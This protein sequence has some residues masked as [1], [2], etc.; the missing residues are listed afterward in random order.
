MSSRSLL[1]GRGTLDAG[2]RRLNPSQAGFGRASPGSYST[3]RGALAADR[4]GGRA[5]SFEG[6][7]PLDRI[8]EDNDKRAAA[9]A[10]IERKSGETVGAKEMALT[11]RARDEDPALRAAKF[12]GIDRRGEGA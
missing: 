4:E 10:G 1:V 11:K 8:D 5:M 3:G 7:A 2:P 6:K 12:A 9:F